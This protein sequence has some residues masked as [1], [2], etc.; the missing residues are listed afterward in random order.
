MQQTVNG[1]QG[2]IRFGAASTTYDLAT[3]ADVLAAGGYIVDVD[4]TRA[5]SG[6]ASIFFGLDPALVSSTDGGAAFLAVNGATDA[7]FLIQDDGG[8]GGRVQ[9]NTFGGGATN[10]DNIVGFS[11]AS[12]QVAVRV[13]VS[14]PDGFDAGDT[15]N[16]AISI[17]GASVTSQDVVLDGTGGGF[18]GFSANGPGAKYDNLTISAIPE[19]TSLA[20][21][22][23]SGAA[24]L[25]RRRR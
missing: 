12:A 15:A 13:I 17:N 23:L 21:L 9:F 10:F 5:A 11:D 3:D 4:V 2:V 7:T 22:G 14:A 16:F 25:A 24:V 6:F 19:P 18:V 1:S 20:L 8:G